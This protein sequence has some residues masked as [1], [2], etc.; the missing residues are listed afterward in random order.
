MKSGL[1]VNLYMHEKKGVGF[2][3][4]P[5]PKKDNSIGKTKPQ[6]ELFNISVSSGLGRITWIRCHCAC[7]NLNFSFTF[8]TGRNTNMRLSGRP[9]RH[10]GVLGTSKLYVIRNQI[11]TFTPQVRR[12]GQQQSNKHLF[13]KLSFSVWRA[14]LTAAGCTCKC[15]N[16]D[17]R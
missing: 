10:I 1:W 13:I 2:L 17:K 3:I 11:F 16:T 7:S 14:T 8:Y 6:S 12:A 5:C 4:H 9:Y 15:S